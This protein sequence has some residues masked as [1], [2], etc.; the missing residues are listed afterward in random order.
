MKKIM[1]LLGLLMLSTS[2]LTLDGQLRVTE[3]FNVKKKGGFLN[4]K[5][6]DVTGQA[7]FN[8]DLFLSSAK[9]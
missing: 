6:K 1:T 3:S 8:L 5:L 2:C 4:L 9:I 7:L